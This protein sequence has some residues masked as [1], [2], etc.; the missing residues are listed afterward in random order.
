MTGD[1]MTA[2]VA[3]TEYKL[4]LISSMVSETVEVRCHDLCC[5]RGS[6]VFYTKRL[7]QTPH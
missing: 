2:K 6:L 5:F 4:Q 3:V 1:Q 7:L